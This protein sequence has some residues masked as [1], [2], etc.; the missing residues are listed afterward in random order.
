L[1]E[2]PLPQC[3]IELPHAA[4]LLFLVLLSLPVFAADW[5]YTVAEGD[6]L[7]DLSE[8]H[9]DSQLRFEQVR[10]LNNVKFPKRMRPG[11]RL[12]IP[13]EWIRSNPVPARIDAIRGR[14][15]LTR[16]DGTQEAD[17]STGSTIH[18][19]D[20]LKTGKNSSAAVIFAD[21]SV[22]T[23]HS[24][25][26]MRFDHLSAHGETGMVD[27]R[28]HLI[29]GRLDTRVKP[30]VGPG[31]RFEIQTP[32]AISA[33]RGT[34]YRAAIT[35]GG[36]SSNIEVLRGKVKVTGARKPR[37]V[38]TGFGTQIAKGKAPTRPRR[39]LPAPKLDPV[40]ER[41]RQLNWPLTWQAI[42]KAASYRVE[43]GA[44]QTIGTL[45]WEQV[46]PHA[47]IPLPDLPDG[48]YQVRVRGI[49]SQGLEGT[50]SVKPLL[51]DTHPQP[52]VPLTPQEGKTL[53]G[54][55]AE[56]QWTASADADKY[57]LE[58]AADKAFEQVL[59]RQPDLKSTRFRTDSI[60][61]PGTYYWRVTSIAADGEL[62][63]AGGVRSWNLKPLP[64]KVEPAVESEDD[65]L[66]A[67]WPRAT[68]DQSYQVQLARDRGFKD[69][70]IDET[71]SEP[72]IGFT[73]P[74]GGVRYLRVRSI[75]PDGYQGPWG[76]VQRID[77]PSDPGAWIV[78]LVGV[79][80]FLLL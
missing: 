22:L 21:G 49:D 58:I 10:R 61:D 3:R 76:T 1:K 9:L 78:P 26:E 8:K 67:S 53:R 5:I 77:P 27:S 34:E 4:A 19:G 39:L 46:V 24:A 69:L 52:P 66:I 15:E 29:D 59:L 40:P 60:S 23:L 31:S 80:G 56:L 32:S 45:V 35:A 28:L 6:N 20:S 2:L 36:E 64:E 41:I 30:A 17:L 47:R 7:W 55:A 16:A 54:V 38:A 51:I 73:R 63:P 65:R 13:M 75:E 42:N 48:A 68:A 11:T 43:I 50:N 57:L 14:V 71:T 62:G 72:G 18:L 37:L 33:V 70:E 25:S 74:S 79:L 12:R 44:G